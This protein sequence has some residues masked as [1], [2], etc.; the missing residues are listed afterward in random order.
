MPEEYRITYTDDPSDADVTVIGKGIQHYN[1]EQAGATGHHRLC[2][3]LRAPNQKVVGGLLGSTYW[4]WFYIDLLWVADELR[5]QGHGRRLLA[6]AEQEARQR[7]AKQAYLDTFSFQ[8]PDFYR[9]Q[10]YEA[11]GE[12]HDFPEGHQRFFFRKRL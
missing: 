6:L 1:E 4:N 12:L 5:G 7:G 3:F 11:F 9:K 10:G 8:A 2:L